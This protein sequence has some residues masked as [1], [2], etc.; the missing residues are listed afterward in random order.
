MN[1][2]FELLYVRE[3][4][5]YFEAAH[6]I[7]KQQQHQTAKAAKVIVLV[8]AAVL[9]GGL[10]HRM[11]GIGIV[12]LAGWYILH[13]WKEFLGKGQTYRTNS[14]QIRENVWRRVVQAQRPWMSY[15]VTPPDLTKIYKASCLIP[16]RHDYV[17]QDD[18]LSGEFG[19][20]AF[21]ASFIESGYLVEKRSDN[22]VR[23]ERHQ[24]FR[25]LFLVAEFPKEFQGWVC[26]QSDKMEKL[27]WLA[28]EWRSAQDPHYVR[29]D[30]PDFEQNFHVRASDPQLAHYL[31]SSS[32]MSRMID[33]GSRYPE[34]PMILTMKDS[35]LMIG[36][37]RN[38]NPFQWPDH[39]DRWRDSAET[40]AHVSEQVADILE[41]LKINDDI[42][43]KTEA[44]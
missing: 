20:S 42:W 12:L 31:L 23:Y 37:A 9:I 26:V 34:V 14:S 27:G 6:A 24:L 18:C 32:F 7:F 41:T 15:H 11:I 40:V 44:A 38:K 17:Q 22:Q 33:L 30:N 3:W 29:M 1:S 10:I 5:P 19:K 2:N 43:E 16:G 35:T 4:K 39:E 13:H 36:I 25:G 8:F 21:V 28:N